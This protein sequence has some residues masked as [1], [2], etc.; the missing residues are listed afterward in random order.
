M[1]NSDAVSRDADADV[2]AEA[3]SRRGRS[4]LAK[5]GKKVT[6]VTNIAT[7]VTSATM[8]GRRGPILAKEEA[9]QQVL[10]ADEVRG[11]LC[12]YLI[13]FRA[14]TERVQIGSHC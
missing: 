10:A 6:L 12:L 9:R 14:E 1:P 7:L 5:G 8:R 2:A 13:H 4:A 11:A 3:A